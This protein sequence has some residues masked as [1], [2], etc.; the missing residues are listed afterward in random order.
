MGT[1]LGS[2][3][4]ECQALTSLFSGDFPLRHGW[5]FTPALTHVLLTPVG[6][7][8]LALCLFQGLSI[9][10]SPGPW[11]CLF[12]RGVREALP[13]SLFLPCNLRQLRAGSQAIEVLPPLSCPSEANLSLPHV[14]CGKSG[15]LIDSGFYLL[16][17]NVDVTRW[18]E[19]RD[20]QF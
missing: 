13:V 5:L 2:A 3:L 20:T 11:L 7:W 14:Q 1:A 19:S 6:L 16:Q 12:S 4:C 9:L 18:L 17:Y 10:P 15:C 8:V